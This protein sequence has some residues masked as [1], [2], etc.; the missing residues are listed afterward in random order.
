[1]LS[2]VLNSSTHR[3]RC[4]NMHTIWNWCPHI[5]SPKSPFCKSSWHI[6][7]IIF[8]FVF[9]RFLSKNRKTIVEQSKSLPFNSTFFFTFAFSEI[10]RIFR[11]YVRV[12]CGKI[13]QKSNENTF[14]WIRPNSLWVF[15]SHSIVH[16]Y[17]RA[18]P[19]ETDRNNRIKHTNVLACISV[20][21]DVHSC[22]CSWIAKSGHTATDR[23]KLCWIGLIEYTHHLKSFETVRNAHN[24]AQYCKIEQAK[25]FNKTIVIRLGMSFFLISTIF[26]HFFEDKVMICVICQE[27]LGNE[28][29][30]VLACEHQFHMDCIRRHQNVYVNIEIY[31]KALYVYI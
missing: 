19:S 24:S 20:E 18:R 10:F 7:Q 26:R 3:I 14:S 28:E 5:S 25:K 13:Q 1:M 4:R 31:W 23:D 8:F 11:C 27:N 15:R 2:N 29:L 22:K 21:I 16:F 12:R 17:E 6:T 9:Y 30:G